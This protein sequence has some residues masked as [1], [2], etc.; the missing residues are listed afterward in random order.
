MLVGRSHSAIDNHPTPAAALERWHESASATLD[1]DG[2]T[3]R[4]ERR[5]ADKIRHHVRI[6][7]DI[8]RLAGKNA[9]LDRFLDQ[10]AIQAARA[11]FFDIGRAAGLEWIVKLQR[12]TSRRWPASWQ[13]SACMVRVT[14]RTWT[15]E[16]IRI[17]LALRGAGLN[18]S[19]PSKASRSK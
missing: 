10:A 8:G 7:V 12:G 6:L 9:D 4:Q 5:S 16:Q 15:P 11:R 1:I 2:G 3:F 17:L 18:N 14:R 19:S 13:R